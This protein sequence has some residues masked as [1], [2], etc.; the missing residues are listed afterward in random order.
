MYFADGP[1]SSLR[2]IEYESM[3]E[4]VNMVFGMLLPHCTVIVDMSCAAC[5]LQSVISGRW[6]RYELKTGLPFCISKSSSL[7]SFGSQAVSADARE[8]SGSAGSPT[9]SCHPPISNRSWSTGFSL[10]CGT[11][12]PRLEAVSCCVARN[13]SPIAIAATMISVVPIMKWERTVR[14]NAAPEERDS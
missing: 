14:K 5:H 2:V 13:D 6:C 7:V 3:F 12:S 9:N 1:P 4:T 10:A 8:Q 11:W